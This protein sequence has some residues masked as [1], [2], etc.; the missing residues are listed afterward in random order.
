[1]KEMK[2][3]TVDEMINYRKAKLF[4]LVRNSEDPAIDC[5]KKIAEEMSIELRFVRQTR[6]GE[7]FDSGWCYMVHP[8]DQLPIC[9]GTVDQC[10][11]LIGRYVIEPETYEEPQTIESETE[12]TQDE[13][14]CNPEPE[15]VQGAE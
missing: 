7:F 3:C 13:G 12:G 14:D 11:W 15:Q 5:I 8:E 2:P 1:M 10:A 9:T 4:H 6:I